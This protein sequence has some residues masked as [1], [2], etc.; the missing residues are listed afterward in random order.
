[1]PTLTT[2]APKIRIRFKDANY[3]A[4]AGQVIAGNLVRGSNGQF[5][6]GSTEQQQQERDNQRNQQQQERRS[7]LQRQRQERLNAKLQ[8]RR[9]NAANIQSAQLGDDAEAFSFLT[10]P[11]SNTQPEDLKPEYRNNLIKRGL[12]QQYADGS[13]G[14]TATAK[15]YQKASEKGDTKAAARLLATAKRIADKRLAKNP[16]TKEIIRIRFKAGPTKL[17]RPESALPAEWQQTAEKEM[18]TGAMLAF[19]LPNDAANQL[20]QVVP[21]SVPPEEMHLTLCYLGQVAEL[22]YSLPDLQMAVESFAATAYPIEGA[23]SG[24]GRFTSTD[25][26]NNTNA[27]YASFDAP[28]LPQFRQDLVNCLSRCG[29]EYAENH[30][31]TPHITLAYLDKAAPTPDVKLPAMPLKFNRLVLAWG[32]EQIEFQLGQSQGEEANLSP[33]YNSK[34][35]AATGAGGLFNLAGLSPDVMNALPLPNTGD[36]VTWSSSGGKARGRVVSIHKASTVR[37]TPVKTVGTQDEPAARIEIY[38]PDEAGEWQPTGSHIAHRLSD[39]TKL[40]VNKA[41]GLTVFKQANGQYRWITYSSSGYLDRDGEFVP[42]AELEA[43]CDRAD[44]TKEYG[45]LCWW[46]LPELRIGECDFNMVHGRVLIESGTFD[47]PEVAQIF[48]ECEE[49]LG[50]SICFGYEARPARTYQGIRRKER[51]LLPAEVASNLLTRLVIEGDTEDMAITKEEKVGLFEKLVG[52]KKVEGILAG[53]EQV[54]KEADAMGLA[55]KAAG[56]TT[57]PATDPTMA[58]GSGD[59][60]MMD[61]PED[62]TDGG[63]DEAT[64]TPNGS[65]DNVVEVAL[66]DLHAQLDQAFNKALASQLPK[67]LAPIQAAIDKLSTATKEASDASS[68]FETLALAYKETTDLLATALKENTEALKSAVSANQAAVARIAQLETQVA[69]LTGDLPRAVKQRASTSPANVVA[70]TEAQKQAAQKQV[71]PDAQAI[72]NLVS[73]MVGGALM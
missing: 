18:H 71:D 39:L 60:S 34:E 14:L 52:R 46:H 9:N 45:P 65:Q 53:A 25:E 69:T 10:D 58:D 66:E 27:F 8:T 30:G 61:D 37:K 6:S 32:G 4:Q 67:T 59:P 70:E 35:I 73:R 41:S 40:S 5:S 72:G 20:A 2:T 42:T 21:D 43:D 55:F 56:D 51:S 26:G 13:Y 48:K 3:G 16:K 47:D 7:L 23:I 33:Y 31:Y 17:N 15:A 12:L 68:N 29:I 54:Q 19:Y 22:P 49:D 1:M 57:D 38:Q 28:L 44:A 63:A 24:F 11:M 62:L 50:V 36:M 64:E